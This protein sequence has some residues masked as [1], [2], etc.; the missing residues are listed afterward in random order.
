M[1]DALIYKILS[2]GSS[3]SMMHC[4]Q[5]QV[6]AACL[7]S[8]PKQAHLPPCAYI[9]YGMLLYVCLASAAVML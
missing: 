1:H 8:L 6:F 4:I 3:E 7:A 2:I 5:K 9:T